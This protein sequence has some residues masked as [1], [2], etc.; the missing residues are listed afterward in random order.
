[1]RRSAAVV[2][3][4]SAAVQIGK[5]Y[6]GGVARAHKNDCPSKNQNRRQIVS[7]S[8]RLQVFQLWF[9]AGQDALS[10]EPYLTQAVHV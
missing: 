5:A 1:M 7:I 6:I 10:A 2:A 3:R 8:Q 9:A 4:A